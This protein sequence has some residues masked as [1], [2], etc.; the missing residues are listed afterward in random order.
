MGDAFTATGWKGGTYGI[1][2]GAHNRDKFF[3]P[4]WKTV[5]LELVGG[6][7]A[8]KVVVS[9]SQS[10]W[11]NCPELRAAAIGRWLMG[12]GLAPWLKGSP[13]RLQLEAQGDGALK[14]VS[15]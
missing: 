6:P 14:V 1:R 12:L 11:Q 10:F 7:E 3:D 15:L 5:E 13:P 9:V 4:D 2:V 8:Q